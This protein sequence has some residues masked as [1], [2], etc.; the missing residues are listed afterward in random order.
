MALIVEDGTGK[1]DA[2]SYAD[3]A[4]ANAYVTSQGGDATWDATGD[5]AKEAALR[6][7]TQYVDDTFEP[8]WKGWRKAAS[9]ALRW[10]RQGVYDRDGYQLASDALPLRLKQATAVV[11]LEIALGKS[12]FAAAA[13]TESLTHEDIQVGSLRIAQTFS[14]AGQSAQPSIPKAEALVQDLLKPAGMPV[15]G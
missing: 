10:P 14:G 8:Q 3:L 7:A 1:A 15:R 12:P 6:K 2:E 11:A 13:T 5:P 4:F 9:Q